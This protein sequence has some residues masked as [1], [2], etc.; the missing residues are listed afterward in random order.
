VISSLI[1]KTN[2][3]QVRK[4]LS[5]LFITIFPFV[6]WHLPPY[7]ILS[8]WGLSAFI[9]NGWIKIP[10]VSFVVPKSIIR[11]GPLGPGCSKIVEVICGCLLW[12]SSYPTESLP[13]KF[14]EIPSI[15]I[16]IIVAII[17]CVTNQVLSSWSEH[18]QSRGTHSGVNMMVASSRGRPLLL[19]ER[20][21]YFGI[22]AVNAICEEIVS[23][24]FWMQ[25]FIMRGGLSFAEANFLQALSFGIW[26]YHGIPSGYLGV[27]LTFFYGLVMGFMFKYGG[28]LFLPVLGH[29]L[30]DYFI[31]TVIARQ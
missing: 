16:L 20:L 12:R 7:S 29:T 26:H 8:L 6:L 19:K 27:T 23:R 25:E 9:L 30:A 21:S 13:I 5:I 10:I 22:A 14:G 11:G 18:T 24:G 31:F 1:Q 17:A 2:F 15:L 4:S 3:F 28:G